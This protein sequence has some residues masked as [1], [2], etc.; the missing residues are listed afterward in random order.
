M[1][2]MLNAVAASSSDNHCAW[3]VCQMLLHEK[4]FAKI[5]SSH[6]ISDTKDINQKVPIVF[7]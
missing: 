1:K 7:N 6:R 5:R 3:H 4:S 2:L